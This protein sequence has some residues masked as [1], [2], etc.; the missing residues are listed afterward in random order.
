MPPSTATIPTPATP[1]VC[2]ATILVEGTEI[3]GTIHVQSIA[4]MREVNRIPSATLHIQDG[5]ASRGTFAVGNTNYFIPGKKIEIKL[6][7]RSQEASV[8]T[9]IVIKHSV[10]IRRSG[11][12]LI[13]ECRDEAVKM[14]SGLK[15]HYYA[16]QKDS[17]ILDEIIGR[18]Q[19]GRDIEATQPTLREVVQYEATDWDFVLCR[20]EANGLLVMVENGKIRIAKPNLKQEP[21]VTATF[22]S[23]IL[24]LDAEM[25][26]RLQSPGIK[27]TSW[28]AS[29]QKVAQEDATEPATTN[30]GNLSPDVLSK[31]MGGSAHVLRHGGKLSPPELKAWADGSLQRAR[32]SKVRG[33]AQFQGFAGV[34]PGKLIDVQGIG[35]RLQGKM[36]VVGVRHQVARGNWQTDVQF[37]L[38][39]EPFADTYNLRPLPAAGLLPAVSGLHTGVVTRLEGDPDGEDRIKV[40][41]PLISEQQEGTWA[42]IATLDAGPQRGTYF[43]P[44]IGD[45]VIVG[46][47]HDDPRYPVVL[48]MCHSSSKPAPVPPADPNHEK[49]YVSR[50]KLKMTFDDEKK[51]LV[52][53][54]PGGNS[55]RLSE[56]D[57]TIE[58]KDQ[59]GNK[60]ILNEAG[61]TIESSKDI[62]LKASK[63]LKAEGLNLNFKAQAAFTAQG[64]SSAELS[65]ASTAVKGSATTTVQGGL[66]RIN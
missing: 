15:S 59:N 4:V 27:A 29:E 17:D 55:I 8:F 43:R 37:G 2:T 28:N 22:G 49:G 51:E 16:D 35:E 3:P 66:V 40:R 20:A 23:T 1:D 7:Y 34:V 47:L 13:V 25:D 39:P 64:T 58:I 45:E 61:I 18:Y 42:R 31:V 32:L 44:E 62:I 10:K 9:G 48:G 19:L 60:L 57:K 65:S 53:A 6:G 38:S 54:T 63:D 14:T 56:A 5:E 30:N 50:A 12:F 46:F 24:E 41:L 11:S 21:A 26:A 36:L 33:R 52:F